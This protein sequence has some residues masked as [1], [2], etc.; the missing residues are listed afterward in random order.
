MHRRKKF[1]KIKCVF[2]F[3]FYY[4]VLNFRALGSIIKN[5]FQK[6][7]GPLKDDVKTQY[8]RIWTMQEKM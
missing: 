6:R 2:F 7:I 3:T 8:G 4:S 5:F 1:P